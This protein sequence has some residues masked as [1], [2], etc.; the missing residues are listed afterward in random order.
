MQD[1]SS[2]KTKTAA[3]SSWANTNEPPKRAGWSMQSQSTRTGDI[4]NWICRTKKMSHEAANNMDSQTTSQRS[5]NEAPASLAL[6]AGSADWQSQIDAL[7]AHTRG[8]VALP[9]DACVM[10][11][12]AAQTLLARKHSEELQQIAEALGMPFAPGRDVVAR[13]RE[14]IASP[15][16]SDVGPAGAGATQQE[17]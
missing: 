3:M 17:K 13:V 4:P 12:L 7:I 1:M 8:F 10:T 2:A 14:L 11:S 9:T 16:N 5:P 6:A 15:N